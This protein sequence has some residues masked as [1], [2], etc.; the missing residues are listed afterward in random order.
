[1]PYCC[2]SRLVSFWAAS[3]TS[4]S[5]QASSGSLS[6]GRLE[7]GPVVAPA[8]DG[9]AHGE[10]VQLASHLL[11]V[12]V[13]E[14]VP[15][16]PAGCRGVPGEVGQL[17]DVRIEGPVA[18]HVRRR[19]RHQLGDG[20]LA[21]ALGAAPGPADVLV[22]HRHLGMLRDELRPHGVHHRLALGRGPVRGQLDLHRLGGEG[23]RLARRLLGAGGE[24]RREGEGRPGGGPSQG[25]T[26]AHPGPA[27][28]APP[29]PPAR[30]V[31][32]PSSPS[33]GDSWI[34]CSRWAAPVLI[35]RASSLRMPPRR[36][37][38][39]APDLPRERAR[40]GFCEAIAS[41][42][43][44]PGTGS[45]RRPSPPAS[46][47]AAARCGRPSASRSSPAWSCPREILLAIAPRPWARVKQPGRAR[48]SGSRS[49]R[50]RG[51][52][53]RNTPPWRYAGAASGLP[54]D[55]DGGDRRP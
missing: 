31:H 36:V 40:A 27:P 48:R 54:E 2:W 22:G 30:P 1:M 14:D 5:V 37:N 35:C 34:A 43:R 46:G 10:H 18:D 51:R 21:V 44:K 33:P 55:L 12:G 28:P 3:K 20:A 26:P 39:A 38:G 50:W 8:A 16:P 29:A 41:G 24:R 52:R 4:L 19:P 6:A 42:R 45:Q 15:L 9:G 32:D 49:P 7:E 53:A 25:V 17:V 47:P 23:G 13:E 11:V